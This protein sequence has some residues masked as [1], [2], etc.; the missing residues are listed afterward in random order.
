MAG[1]AVVL[2]AERQLARA[3]VNSTALLGVPF[4]RVGCYR[5]YDSVELEARCASLNRWQ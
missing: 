4:E 3:G 5:L 1:R 2:V